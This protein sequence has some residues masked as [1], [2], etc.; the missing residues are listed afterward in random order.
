MCS[1]PSPSDVNIIPGFQLR[2]FPIWLAGWWFVYLFIAFLCQS[3]EPWAVPL[4]EKHEPD[5][6]HVTPGFSE[7]LWEPLNLFAVTCA[8]TLGKAAARLT[9]TAIPNLQHGNSSKRANWRE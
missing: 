7:A 6:H 2:L 8:H 1:L 5:F 4:T 9:A 3:P